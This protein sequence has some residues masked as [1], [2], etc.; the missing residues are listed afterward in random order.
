MWL[1][2]EEPIK[3]SYHSAKFGGCRSCGSEDLMI[4]VCHV[5]LKG[6]MIKGSCGFMGRG[7][8]K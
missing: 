1:Y 3:V 4:L 6:H 5:I 8:S 7:P 2:E